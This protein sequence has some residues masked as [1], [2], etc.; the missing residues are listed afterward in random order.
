MWSARATSS[1]PVPLSPV[2]STA[3]V[4]VHQPREDAV[5]LLHRR[6]APDQRQVVLARRLAPPA[7]H[8][9]P[10]RLLVQ[11][12]RDLRQ[13]VLQVEGLGQV[14]VGP[15]L[16]RPDRG[17]DVFCAH[18]TIT[19]R[20]GPAL[21][22]RRQ[23]V[24]RV[25]VRHH[26]V[27]DDD[28]ALALLDPAPER[29]GGAGRVDL[30]AGAGQGLRQHGADGAVVVGDEDGA[31]H[32]LAL[33]LVVVGFAAARPAAAP[34]SACGPGR[35]SHST[36]PPWS[37]M[38]FDTSERPSP[39]PLTCE[40]TKGSKTSRIRF[41]GMPGP[42]SMIVDQQRQ[43]SPA[44]AWPRS[45]TPAR[46]RCADRIAPP[47]RGT[48]SAAFFS[49]VQEHLQQLVG[50]ARASAA[51][52]GRSPRRTACARAKPDLRRPPRAVEH[53]VDVER[54]ALR[55][56]QVAEL[57]DLLDA[58]CRSAPPRRIRPVSSRSRRPSPIDRSC[59]APEIPASGF[60][61]SCASISAMPMTDRAAE[62]CRGC[63][64]SSRPCPAGASA[65]AS[66]PARSCSGAHGRSCTAAAGRPSRPSTSYCEH[67]RA[68]L[69]ARLAD[70]LEHGAV[71]RRRSSQTGAPRA[72]A[73][74]EVQ[75]QLGRRVG[76]R[77]CV[78]SGAEEE[79]RVRAAS[80]QSASKSVASCRLPLAAAADRVGGMRPQD[81]VAAPGSVSAEPGS[82]ARRAGAPS[83]YQPRCLR[84][85]RSPESR[86][87]E[88]EHR[89]VVPG[90]QVDQRRA[91]AA[92]AGT[93][94]PASAGGDLRRAPRAAPARRAR[95]SRPSAP[96]SAQRLAR[97]SA[98]STMSPLAITGIATASLDRA[99]SRAQSA[100]AL[101]ELAAGAAV[102][103]DQ[104]RRPPPRPAARAR[105]VQRA[106]VPAEPHLQRHRH[107]R[108]RRPPPRSAAARGRARASAP[109]RTSRSSPSWPGSP[110]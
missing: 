18:I 83:M 97:A 21:R 93:G 94:R 105:R 17:H 34:G 36:T 33:R 1:L 71:D 49:E 10:A 31:F 38:N 19:G 87:V 110:C 79:R 73:G 107:R 13:H 39:V 42:L 99:R 89:L 95:S 45:C 56:A 88:A 30:A 74:D 28:V 37:A 53:V 25:A 2:I 54:P 7:R 90:D 12:L 76:G 66:R 27:G 58:A 48:A 96:D 104:P 32:G 86:A 98:R 69:A 23:Q 3:E 70:H 8:R 59:A 72:S 80:A 61:I 109:S 103:R 62:R 46:R 40:Q 108:P 9:R 77:G 81:R 82:A 84:A 15:D 78:S 51:A 102:D 60:L 4:G 100:R 68:P 29:R 41:S 47:T 55:R 91:L 106:V 26:H 101:V 24:E 92:P 16:G 20:S 6:R 65:S 63:G 67:R 35:L 5:D 85:T 64:P 22:D 11:R 14:V 44:A 50:V 43:A 75:E 52:T 57:L